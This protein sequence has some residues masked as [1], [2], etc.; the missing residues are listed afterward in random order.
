MLGRRF[1]NLQGR[2]VRIAGA[3]LRVTVDESNDAHEISLDENVTREAMHPADRFEAFRRIADE[4]GWGA[5]EIGARFGVS[6]QLVRQRLRL[7]EA[8]LGQSVPA[9]KVSR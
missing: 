3:R 9:A 8:R 2:A 6:A 1:P 5:E 4:K 7:S